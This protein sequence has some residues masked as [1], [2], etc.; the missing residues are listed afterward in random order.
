MRISSYRSGRYSSEQEHSIFL[1][2][3]SVNSPSAQL[4]RP[5]TLTFMPTMNAEPV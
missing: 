4:L 5:K 3:S 2:N 1:Q